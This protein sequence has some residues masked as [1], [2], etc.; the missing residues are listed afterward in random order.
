MSY[1]L[2]EEFSGLRNVKVRE[3][4]YYGTKLSMHSSLVLDERKK[5]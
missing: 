3:F 4:I 5:H 1:I 2:Y